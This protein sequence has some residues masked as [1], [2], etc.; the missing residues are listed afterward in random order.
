MKLYFSLVVVFVT[1]CSGVQGQILESQKIRDVVEHSNAS[2]LIIFDIDNTLVEPVQE[3]GSDQWFRYRIQRYETTGL[4]HQDAIE[5][6]LAEWIAI[7]SITSIKTVEEDTATVVQELQDEKFVVMGLT[8]RGL[9]M[10]TRT[11]QQLDSLGIDLSRTAPT[12]EEIFF[13][14]GRGVL[15]RKGV[16]FTAATDKGTASQT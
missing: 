1:L 12:Q 3:L 6:A 9:G 10:A 14:N 8:T 15:F 2:T 11:V 13:M 16:L 4:P 7:Q 5:K